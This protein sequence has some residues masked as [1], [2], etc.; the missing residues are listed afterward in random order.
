[1]DHRGHNHERIIHFPD[2]EPDF[3]RERIEE[4]GWGFMYNAFPPTNITMV[5]EF[6]ANFS[7]AHQEHMFLRGR[8]IHFFE[9]DICRYLGIHIYLPELD[10]DDA[11]KV[12]VER[13]KE[14]NLEMKLIFGVIGRQGTNWA[15][16]PTDNTIPESWK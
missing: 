16:N 10:V 4:L 12:A 6:C 1:M 7:V 3:M 15:N 8:R 5:W 9:N 13:R 2:E 11:F 14:N